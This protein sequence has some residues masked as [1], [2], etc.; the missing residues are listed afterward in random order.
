MLTQPYRLA[1]TAPR[2]ARAQGTSAAGDAEGDLSAGADRPGDAVGAG[3]GARLLVNA[4]VIDGEPAGHPGVDR[5]RF[6][7]RN[8][9]GPGQLVEHAAG[10]IGGVPGSVSSQLPACATPAAACAPV[11]EPCAPVARARTPSLPRRRQRGA[12]RRHRHRRRTPSPDRRPGRRAGGTGRSSPQP[13]TRGSSR[14]SSRRR[15]PTGWCQPQ[16]AFPRTNRECEIGGVL[17]QVLRH[18]RPRRTPRRPDREA[19]PRQSAEA[20]GCEQLRAVP[21]LPPARTDRKRVHDQD[22]QLRVAPQ[23]LGDAEPGLAGTDDQH[24][25]VRRQILSGSQVPQRGTA[26]RLD[27]ALEPAPDRSRPA[28]SAPVLDVRNGISRF[29]ASLTTTSALTC[30]T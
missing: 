3:R 6:D 2:A 30:L 29:A 9:P 10:P 19:Q 27:P 11:P 22:A 5:S 26:H 25:H 8:Q 1:G 18:L 4:E 7:Q 20:A 28:S 21:A 13:A 15:S 12:G 24:V 14:D 16:D 23:P 17:L